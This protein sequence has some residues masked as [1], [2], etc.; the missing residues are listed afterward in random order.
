MI[1][2]VRAFASNFFFA[3]VIPIA[4]VRAYACVV[5]E[6]QALSSLFFKLCRTYGIEMANA[7]TVYSLIEEF[8]QQAHNRHVSSNPF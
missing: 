2:F 4:C 8:L 1:L 3:W 6:N 7:F 5:N